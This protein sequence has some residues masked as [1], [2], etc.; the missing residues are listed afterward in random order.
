MQRVYINKQ[1]LK[2]QTE[3]A[4]EMCVICGNISSGIIRTR[5]MC[6]LHFNVFQKDNHHRSKI[7]NPTTNL[8][9][10]KSCCR[11]KCGNKKEVTVSKINDEIFCSE[12]CQIKKESMSEYNI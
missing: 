1:R 6:G 2:D 10:F 9:L 4:E 8:N 7:N 3:I 12:E 11:Y 5:P